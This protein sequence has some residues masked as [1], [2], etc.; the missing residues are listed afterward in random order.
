[1][2]MFSL[3][4]SIGRNDIQINSGTKNEFMFCFIPLGVGANNGF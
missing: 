4:R 2:C 1:M 3:Y